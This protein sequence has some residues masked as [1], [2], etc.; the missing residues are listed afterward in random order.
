MQD[1]SWELTGCMPRAALHRASN[2]LDWMY[3]GGMV[4]KAEADKR[5][6]EQLLGQ[7]AADLSNAA[8]AAPGQARACMRPPCPACAVRLDASSA[9]SDDMP[10]R[11]TLK[12]GMSGTSSR[13]RHMHLLHSRMQ[14]DRR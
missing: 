2:R 5:S 12:R 13:W 10:A 4:A 3:Q 8:G 14:G 9:G 11:Q 6:E 1:T 7:R